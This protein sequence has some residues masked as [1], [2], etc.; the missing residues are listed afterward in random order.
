MQA[1]SPSLAGAIRIGAPHATLSGLIY[2][3]GLP[4][5]AADAPQAGAVRDCY[6][7][8]GNL[9]DF[10]GI[11]E[12]LYTLT[13]YFSR[14][15]RVFISRSVV[16]DAIN[17]IIDEFSRPQFVQFLHDIKRTYPHTRFIVMA[18]EFITR[19]EIAGVT[20]GNTFNFFGYRDDARL[21]A[22]MLAY[23]LRVKPLPPYLSSRY[24]GFVQA[25][26]AIDLVVCAHEAVAETMSLLPPDCVRPGQPPLTLYPEVDIARV[27][28]DPR[29]HQRPPGVMM[30]G[31]M[32]HFRQGIA[33]NLVHGLN[34][35]GVRPPVYR[36][37]PFSEAPKFTLGPKGV[38]F[39]YD[40][41]GSNDDFLY[42][43]NPP[44]RANWR[45]SSPMRI[46]RAILLGQ[47]PVLTHRF[48][49]HEIEDVAETFDGDRG[50]AEKLWIGA[51][52]GRHVLIARYLEKVAQYGIVARERNRAIDLAL[53]TVTQ[54]LPPV[55]TTVPARTA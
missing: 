34:L 20:F 17:V 4:V 16:P 10:S 53:A 32:T 12:A 46:L 47:I 33:S 23:K 54:D 5:A 40:D 45:Y 21:L 35:V 37:V 49:D 13:A 3:V 51:T 11:G 55:T 31:T 8:V 22:R 36:H 48:G 29:L 14:H 44:Q 43:L 19:I 30:T 52:V 24:Q 9:N 27:S 1:H 25:L 18:T 39:G 7:V 38:D 50:S 2:P 41:A 6:L 42:N 15:F 28:A 26:P